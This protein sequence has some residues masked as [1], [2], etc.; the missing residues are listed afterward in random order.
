M[1]VNDHKV[2]QF[3]IYSKLIV[4]IQDKVSQNFYLEGLAVTPP[5]IRKLG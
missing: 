3:F 2:I 4:D 5:T 1:L